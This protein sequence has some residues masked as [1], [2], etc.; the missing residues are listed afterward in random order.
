MTEK[1]VL[2]VIRREVR[3]LRWYAFMATAAIALLIFAAFK[4]NAEKHQFD[5]IDVQRI[6]I[7]EK[8]GKPRIILANRSMAPDLIIKGK[9]EQRATGK[10]SPGIIFF[11]DE[12]TECGALSTASTSGENGSYTASS[13]L[14]FDQFQSDETVALQY[15]DENGKRYAGLTV[16]DRPEIQITPEITAKV[17][18]MWKLPEGPAKNQALRKLDSLGVFESERVFIGKTQRKSATVNLSDRNG[19]LRI[20]LWVDSLGTP[21]LDFLDRSGNVTCRLPDSLRAIRLR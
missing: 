2:A 1:E 4:Q 10:N 7:V 13:R 19:N 21:R 15:I 17:R 16:M 14:V 18:S 8:D 11:N 9:T 6:N 5:E 12:G 3:V 20:R